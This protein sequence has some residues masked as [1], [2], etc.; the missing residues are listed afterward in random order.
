MLPLRSR[1]YFKISILPDS[2]WAT[3]S[4]SHPK[5]THTSFTKFCQKLKKDE[6]KTPQ[7]ARGIKQLLCRHMAPRTAGPGPS[8]AGCGHARATPSG[9]EVC[10]CR[11]ATAPGA[12]AA[13][14]TGFQP[15]WAVRGR[16]SLMVGPSPNRRQAAAQGI[17]ARE[18]QSGEKL[19]DVIC[20]Y[21]VTFSL[22]LQYTNYLPNLQEK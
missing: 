21:K 3:P 8:W 11:P 7:G 20:N 12:A 9:Q 22:R 15:G 18:L 17:S 5:S 1:R 10:G 19:L 14:L 2:C 4:V 13:K 16:C 6:N